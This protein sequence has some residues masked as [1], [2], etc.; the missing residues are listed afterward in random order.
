MTGPREAGAGRSCSQCG[1]GASSPLRPK[2]VAPGSFQLSGSFTYTSPYLTH[3][4]ASKMCVAGPTLTSQA[5]HAVSRPSG[6]GSAPP[7]HSDTE[8]SYE[9]MEEMA[10]WP[11][12][13]GDLGTEVSHRISPEHEIMV[14][15][16]RPESAG[17]SAFPQHFL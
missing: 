4:S 13:S 1:L 17:Q 12:R 2:T 3:C 15:G 7:T 9:V 6:Y 5:T 14:R 10:I 16:T 8:G 11:Q